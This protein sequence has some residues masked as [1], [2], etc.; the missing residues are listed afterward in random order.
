MRSLNSVYQLM[1]IYKV[2]QVGSDSKRIAEVSNLLYIV[3]EK[4]KDALAFHREIEEAVKR[5]QKEDNY[6]RNFATVP[7]VGVQQ[8]THQSAVFENNKLSVSRALPGIN[9]DAVIR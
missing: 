3:Q 4:A 2:L 6:H 9:L 8:P 1:P 5:N 7:F